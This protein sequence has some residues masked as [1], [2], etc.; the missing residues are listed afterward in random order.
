MEILN[1]IW[2]VLTTENEMVAS[3]LSAPLSLIEAIVTTLLFTTVL[4]INCSKKQKAYYILSLLLLGLV[5]RFILPDPFGTLLNFVMMIFLIKYIL[6]TSLLKSVIAVILPAVIIMF[7]EY[8]FS[9]LY[10]QLFNISFEQ[11]LYIPLHRIVIS[12]I[13]YFMLFIAYLM[14]KKFKLSV[15]ILDC[16]NTSNRRILFA[17]FIFTILTITFQAYLTIFYSV[18]LPFYITLI[19]FFNTLIYFFVNLIILSKTTKLELTSLDLEQSN[20]YNKTLEI[21]H[22]NVRCF[23]HDFNNIITTIGG[24]VQ[25]EDL[26]GLKKYYS[27]LQTDCEKI[28]NLNILNPSTINEPAIYSLLTNKYHL[29]ENN[30]IKINIE[31]FI[32][33]RQLRMKVY[34]FTR[35]LGILLDNAIEA[36][37]ECEEKIINISIRKDF[38]SDRQLLIIEN[39][40]KNKDIDTEKIYDK[41]Y[42]T[43]EHN[44][45]IGL[46]EVRQILKKN[47]NLNLFTSKNEKFFSQQLE[48]Y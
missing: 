30:G 14:F 25:S 17:C 20:Q 10:I 36:S 27:N 40:Y 46:W 38:H 5:S 43:K 22:D 21:L 24:Y 11:C 6:T 18:H 8:I 31:V 47:N 29:A 37:N 13:I 2:S 41:G 3:I 23:K 42:S 4:D 34:E 12:L 26:N 16:M 45:G 44:T 35:I 48:I 32:D 19:A 1:S 9:N 39:T 28:N 7:F 15:S 33:L